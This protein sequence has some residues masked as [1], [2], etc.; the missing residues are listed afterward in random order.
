MA[1]AF[2][3]QQSFLVRLSLETHRIVTNPRVALSVPE[4][5]PFYIVEP[6]IR[7]AE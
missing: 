7:P 2:N 6:G 5:L 4:I 1:I 3:F